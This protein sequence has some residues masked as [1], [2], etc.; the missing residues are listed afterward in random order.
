MQ[1][2]AGIELSEVEAPA[3]T[4]LQR[5]IRNYAVIQAHEDTRLANALL[6]LAD[7]GDH[8]A[9]YLQGSEWWQRELALACENTRWSSGDREVI[10]DL[11]ELRTAIAASAL[12]RDFPPLLVC[13]L[14]HILPEALDGLT[15]RGREWAKARATAEAF[16]ALRS[17]SFRPA[18]PPEA[19]PP[20]RT[21]RGRRRNFSE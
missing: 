21:T 9:L 12:I 4:E 20:V 18:P 14:L 19:E 6:K 7:D 2:T 16:Q 3:L 1:D 13:E 11:F 8:A 15:Q 5:G 17:A 10:A